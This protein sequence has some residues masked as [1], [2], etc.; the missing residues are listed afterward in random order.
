MYQKIILSLLLTLTV[1]VSFAPAKRIGVFA[2][3]SDIGNPKLT[4]S[5]SFDKSAKVY[6]LTGA[7][8]NIWFAR[9]EFQFLYKELDGD[10][11][12]TADFEFEGKGVDP[13]RKV[14]WM[15]RESLYDN[16][17]HVSA[18]LHGDGLTV[19]QWRVKKGDHMRDPEDE[20]FSAEKNIQTIQL[21][22]KGNE[23]TMMAA[24]KGTPL[25]RVGTHQ[26]DNLPD[27]IIAGMFICSHNPEVLETARVSNVQVVMD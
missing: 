1:F 18:V 4:G 5:S 16:A 8:Y 25:Q 15:I 7:G 11:T 12:L 2:I 27:K 3:S 10:F 20:I 24:Q 22:R 23:Y 13:H 9:D 19:M 14:G 6:T 26:M 21:R 17:S